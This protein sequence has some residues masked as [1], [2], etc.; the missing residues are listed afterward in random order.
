MPFLTLS[1]RP[2]AED[3]ARHIEHAVNVCGVDHV[4]IGTD[5]NATAIDD[6]EAYQGRLEEE[7]AD[8]ARTGIGAKGERA[9]THPFVVDLRGVE[10]FRRL[11]ALLAAR[12][13]SSGRIE[14][15][16]GANFLAFAREVWGA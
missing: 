2:T 5:G 4:G 10:Q 11:Q 9:D 15:I 12:G 16:M 8:R 13:F 1:G 7:V 6:L 14:K 3:V